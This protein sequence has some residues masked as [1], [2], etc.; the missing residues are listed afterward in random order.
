[1]RFFH[2]AA[3]VALAVSPLAAALAQE[4]VTGVANP[5]ALFTD[6]DPKLNRNKQAAYHIM[7]DLL[8]ANQWDKAGTWLTDKY[9]QHNPLAASG[10]KGVI[11]YFTQV[12]KRVP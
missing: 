4:P 7:K 8:E 5:E 2:A 3:A 10:L 6:K 11:Y 1:M 9:I 12:A